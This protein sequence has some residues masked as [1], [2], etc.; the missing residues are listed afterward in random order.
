M[1][2]KSRK[3]AEMETVRIKGMGPRGT[4]IKHKTPTAAYCR[5][6]MEDGGH[7]REDTLE[8]QMTLVKDFIAKHEELELAEAYVD[9]GFTGTNFERPAFRDMIEAVRQGKIR[10]IVVKDLSRFGRNYLEAG[11]YIETVF[12]FLEVRLL[13]VTDHFDSSRREDVEGLSIP[14]KNL[15]NDLYAKD[16]SQKIWS[17]NQQLKKEG[18]SCGNCAPYGYIRN[19]DTGRYEIDR[20]TAPFVQLMYHWAM[21]G[22]AEGEIAKRLDLLGAPTPRTRLHQLGYACAPQNA[23]WQ[24]SSVRGILSNRAYIGD[25]VTNKTNQAYFKG[26]KKTLLPESMWVITENTH[27]PLIAKDDYETVQKIAEE[28]TAFYLKCRAERDPLK[29]EDMMKGMVFCAECGKRM[30]YD[31]LPH[32]RQVTKKVSYYICKGLESHSTCRGQ[33]IP[34]ELLKRQVMNNVLEYI[35]VFCDREATLRQTV[36]KGNC[37]PLQRARNKLIDLKKQESAVKDKKQRLYMDFASGII[38]ADEYRYTNGMYNTQQKE[39]VEGLAKAQKELEELERSWKSIK[40]RAEQWSRY[41]GR[42]NSAFDAGLVNEMV[43]K[44]IVSAD[45]AM[46]IVFRFSDLAEKFLRNAEQK[47]V[48]PVS[49]KRRGL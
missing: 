8:T 32:K 16:I 44:I 41:A 17:A 28:K 33:R 31:R 5:L 6:S 45:G 27:M 7:G 22:Y 15:V 4:G 46:E 34:A 30:G 3:Q 48:D 42:E 24:T 36:E 1:A 20:Q 35:R 29:D 14:I 39:A 23:S 37:P 19:R 12:P 26:Q 11:Y 40:D 9:N 47:F 25:S 18:K 13:S 49:D 43:E 21:T 10:C 38:N 2:R